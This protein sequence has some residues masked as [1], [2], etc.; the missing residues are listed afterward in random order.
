MTPQKVSL[1]MG[2]VFSFAYVFSSLSPVVVGYL[3][4]ATGTF[5]LGFGLWAAFSWVLALGGLLLPETGPGRTRGRLERVVPAQPER[6]AL[7]KR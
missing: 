5:T 6:A 4:D 7:E 2:T 1:M 3:R